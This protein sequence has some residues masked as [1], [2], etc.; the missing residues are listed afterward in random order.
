MGASG[1][2]GRAVASAFRARGDDVTGVVRREGSAPP[3]VHEH[4]GALGEAADW[5]AVADDADLL[6][7]CA[8][9]WSADM[10][11]LEAEWRAALA[12]SRFAGRIVYTG[13]VWCFGPSDGSL[14]TEAT[15]TVPDPTFQWADDSWDWLQPRYD[16][17]LV[18]P[19][20]VWS[21]EEPIAGPLAQPGTQLWPLVADTDLAEGYVLAADL[22]P[23]GSD[24]LMVSEILPVDEIAALT[25]RSLVPV[26][27]TN[28]YMWNQPVSSEAARHALGWRPCATPLLDH[29]GKAA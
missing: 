15:P 24:F 22:A 21:V 19:G 7:H 3:G 18:H 23:R 12:A 1:L 6:I 25:G 20:L 29:L 26:A 17:V 2:I 9:D 11:V 13:G 14:I 27:A 4:V 5:I 16:A 28:P 8:C 10:A